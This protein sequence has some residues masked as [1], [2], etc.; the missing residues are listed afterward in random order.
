[1]FNYT[2]ILCARALTVMYFVGIH[3]IPQSYIMKI[4]TKE[5]KCG[6][7]SDKTENVAIVD[8]SSGRAQW[9]ES[10]SLM[11]RKFI[12]EGTKNL[13]AYEVAKEDM[14]LIISK[15]A[16]LNK[17]LEIVE[18]LPNN[19]GLEHHSII[20]SQSSYIKVGLEG[21]V[22]NMGFEGQVVKDPPQSQCKSKRRHQRIKLHAEK[23]KKS[24]TCAKCKRKGHNIRTCK[25]EPIHEAL[26]DGN[27]TSSDGSVDGDS[28]F[29][30]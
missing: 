13:K 10:L 30:T 6:M 4:W 1:M 18:S 17:E 27:S 25:E 2:S 14:E 8:A 22:A 20:I 21:Q 24:R 26:N 5:E 16:S 23:A 28:S 12:N 9:H 3:H 15:L 29:S 19:K 11:Y 7:P